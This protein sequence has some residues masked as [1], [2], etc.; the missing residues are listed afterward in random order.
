MKSGAADN[1]LLSDS[2]RVSTREVTCQANSPFSTFVGIDVPRFIANLTSCLRLQFCLLFRLVNERESEAVI[3][4]LDK[5]QRGEFHGRLEASFP[6]DRP[7]SI[8]SRESRFFGK[9]RRRPPARVKERHSETPSDTGEGT[10]GAAE[11]TRS[12]RKTQ[13]MRREGDGEM[14]RLNNMRAYRRVLLRI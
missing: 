8:V 5:W 10:A 11:Y 4:I 1:P 2:T 14:E 12:V 6:D 7:R 3:D 9:R 13:R